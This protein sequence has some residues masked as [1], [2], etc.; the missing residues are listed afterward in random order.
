MKIVRE[1]GSKM[2]HNSD[3]GMMY[4]RNVGKL[5][6]YARSCYQFKDRGPSQLQAR[7]QVFNLRV[8]LVWPIEKKLSFAVNPSSGFKLNGTINEVPVSF[9]LDT[10]AMVTLL[11]KETWSHVSEEKLLALTQSSS[12]QLVGVDRSLLKVYG[13]TQVSLCL[14]G[15][16]VNLDTVVVSPLTTEQIWSFL[17]FCKNTPKEF[18]LVDHNLILPLTKISVFTQPDGQLA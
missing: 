8:S 6:Y 10:G 18:H 3:G 11:R 17:I 1:I 2:V 4:V 9:L 12:L 14:N 5:G 7:S 16:E 15:V 13:S